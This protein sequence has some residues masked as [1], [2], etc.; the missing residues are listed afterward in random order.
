MSVDTTDGD[1]EYG[2]VG[3]EAVVLERYAAVELENREVIVYDREDEEA[4]IQ[5][6]SAVGLA[7]VR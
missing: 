1:E 3:V 5:S 4:W 7:A 2:T 6:E